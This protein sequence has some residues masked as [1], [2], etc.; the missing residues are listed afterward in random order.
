MPS[1][2]AALPGQSQAPTDLLVAAQAFIEELLP[3]YLSPLMSFKDICVHR[4]RGLVMEVGPGE[5]HFA[6]IL[7]SECAG[8]ISLYTCIDLEITA[9]ARELAGKHP[10]NV[11][12][13]VG[14]FLRKICPEPFDF[15]LAA[16]VMPPDSSQLAAWYEKYAECLKSGGSLALIDFIANPKD[17][18][19]NLPDIIFP[20]LHGQPDLAPYQDQLEAWEKDVRAYWP[21]LPTWEEHRTAMMGAG[22]MPGITRCL[23][24]Q[25]IFTATRR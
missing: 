19:P 17:E 10:K 5:A 15:A 1:V 23:H 6:T 11:E 2:L 3:G 12:L 14:D 9:E 8:A 16:F 13:V 21:D 20:A 22:F 25:C 18:D 24:N 4:A 7:L